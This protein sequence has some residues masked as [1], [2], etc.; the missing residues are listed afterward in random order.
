MRLLVVVLVFVLMFVMVMMFVV[1]MV[2]VVAVLVFVPRVM[3]LTILAGDINIK[4]RRRDSASLG[5][6]D[7]QLVSAQIDLRDFAFQR[8]E[9]QSA[10]EQRSEQHIAADSRKTIKV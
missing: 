5:A 3:V 8:F 6:T 4:L 7:S 1:V 9:I 2:V 10:I